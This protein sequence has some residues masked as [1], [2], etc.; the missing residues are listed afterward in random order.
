MT[1]GACAISCRDVAHP[2]VNTGDLVD[3]H[4]REGIR[5]EG[6]A[7]EVGVRVGKCLDP[8]IYRQGDRSGLVAGK[9]KKRLG[10]V[11]QVG[12]ARFGNKAD[13][14]VRMVAL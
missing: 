9:L 4:R 6:P 3:I 11:C 5:R 7:V 8:Y 13:D 14:P 2:V 10:A 1:C 12:N